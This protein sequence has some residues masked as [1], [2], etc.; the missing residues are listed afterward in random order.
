MFG[1]RCKRIQRGSILLQT[2]C[3][4][5]RSIWDSNRDAIP[6]CYERNEGITRRRFLQSAA[7]TIGAQATPIA[8]LTASS[9]SG[10]KQEGANNVRERW[11]DWLERIAEP[12]LAALSHRQLRR[13]M[14]VEALPGH[15]QERAV[16]THLEALGRLL[17]GL[18]PW[19]ELD[20]TPGESPRETRLR[21]RYRGYAQEAIASA[22]DPTSPDYMRF[23]E[24]AQT[25]VDSSFL[26]LAILRAPRQLCD[27]M[28]ATVREKL[29]KALQQERKVQPPYSNWLLFA[30]MNEVLLRR[31]QVPWDRLRVD[32]AFR[33][34]ENWYLGDGIYGDGPQFHA[35][36]YNSYVIH[37]YLLALTDGLQSETTWKPFF[38]PI[39]SRARRYA[40]IQ[41]R[42]IGADGSFPVVGRSITYRAGAFHLLAD[43]ARRDSCHRRSGHRRSGARSP[44]CKRERLM[45]PVHSATAAGCRSASQDTS[46]LLQRPISPQEAFTSAVSLG[47]PW[48]CRHRMLSGQ[49]RMRT[50]RRR[51]CGPGRPRQRIMLYM[52]VRCIAKHPHRFARL[53][54]SKGVS[55][56]S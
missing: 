13:S 46:S 10:A 38:E 40:V 12:V 5:F 36:Y 16:G 32:Y 9:G 6:L 7:L 11:L 24:S 26:A 1:K 56:P 54:A 17:A 49:R 29:V 33:S 14:P 39:V 23:G 55:T 37:P 53:L 20:T 47:C 35:D 43:I 28:P 45:H 51:P 22:V 27:S 31:L 8:P 30:A 50:G 48:D 19:L 21:A 44:P 42:T 3:L 41:E 25:L 52:M 34:L 15:E 18:G 2:D 4:Y